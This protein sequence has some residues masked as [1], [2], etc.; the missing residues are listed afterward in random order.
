M[1]KLQSWRRFRGLLGDQNDMLRNLARGFQGKEA[2]LDVGGLLTSMLVIAGFL[3]SI[4]LLSRWATQQERSGSYHSSR[5]LFRSLCRAHQLDRT[6]RRLL[7]RLAR[8]HQLAQPA[9]LFLEPQRFS[10]ARWGVDFQSQAPAVLALRA[11]LFA[12]HEFAEEK[13][14][15]AA[16]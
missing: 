16:Q 1:D 9:A 14:A 15:E 6:Q 11:R 13:V 2:E 3:L 8:A 5:E 4:W 7:R 12:E 10:P